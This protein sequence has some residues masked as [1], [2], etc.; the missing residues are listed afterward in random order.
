MLLICLTHWLI[1]FRRKKKLPNVAVFTFFKCLQK[2][3]DDL[4]NLQK[5]GKA[6]KLGSVL[7]CFLKLSFPFFFCKDWYECAGCN[8]KTNCLC[9]TTFPYFCLE[10][11]HVQLYVCREV[12]FS[13]G[14]LDGWEELW[15]NK[16]SYWLQNRFK[17][18]SLEANQESENTFQ[19]WLHCTACCPASSA[20][21]TLFADV[22]LSLLSTFALP[23]QSAPGF[24][25]DLSSNCALVKLQ[26]GWL[27]PVIL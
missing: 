27:G 3:V 18:T 15:K 2:S 24:F 22:Y 9:A 12:D 1:S 5:G 21:A 11:S 4:H 17:L 20:A 8:S 16:N 10:V 26:Y 23:A 14:G 19:T 13:S 6:I 7:Y 25:P